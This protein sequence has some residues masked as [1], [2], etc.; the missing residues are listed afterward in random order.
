MSD[1]SYSKAYAEAGV[2]TAEGERAVR[3]IKD[4]VDSTK[5]AGSV[6]SIGGFSGMFDISGYLN[7]FSEP[8]L[9]QSS[10]GV[11][12]KMEIARLMGKWDTIGIDCVAMCV[13]DLICTGARPIT[14]LDTITCGKNQPE[15][16]YQ[17]IKGVAR[18]CRE[19]RCA[20][21]GGEMAE[22][23][24]LM[25][26][27]EYDLQGFATAIASRYS[28]VNPSSVKSGDVIIGLD[29]NGL[30][31]N[32]FSL[33]RKIFSGQE[34]STETLKR[35]LEKPFLES[36]LRTGET[37]GEWLLRPTAIYVDVVQAALAEAGSD[38]H[39]IAHITGGGIYENIPRVL[40]ADG[41]L[42][43]KFYSSSIVDHYFEKHWFALKQIMDLGK[44]SWS[45]VLHTFNPGFGMVLIVE[46][47]AGEHVI[48]AIEQTYSGIRAL[49]VGF[50]SP[51][52]NAQDPVVQFPL[53]GICRHDVPY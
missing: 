32:G 18:G 14:F 44:L 52:E 17:I 4:L 33:I 1:N 45:D 11:G 38:I 29:S 36:L 27:G 5:I 53:T 37:L 15:V 39:A 50:V 2:N 19:A 10:D 3:L 13:N 51:R 9:L 25:E 46:A 42:A 49:R 28:L 24:G 31:S 20:L 26:V 12:T 6:G 8:L 23:P 16:V 35:N 22:H 30:H 34:N 43:A 48:K 41:S 7:E 21:I 40:P 47:T